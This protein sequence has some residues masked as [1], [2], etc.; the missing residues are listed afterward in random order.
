MSIEK[1][2]AVAAVGVIVVAAAVAV[3]VSLTAEEPTTEGDVRVAETDVALGEVTGETVE[4]DTVVRLAHRGGMTE[5]VSVVVRATRTD[6]GLL[7]AEETYDVGEV[8]GD[9]ETEVRVPVVVEREGD[10]GFDV[11]VYAGDERVTTGSKSVSG[12]GTVQPDYATSEL[13]FHSFPLQPAVEFSVSS[14]A[15]ETVELSTVSFLTNEG[16]DR[17]DATLVVKARQADSGIVA[18]EEE[19]DVSVAAGST[20][21]PSV[22]LTVPE[23]YDYYLDATLW[24][25]DNIVA[26]HRSAANLDPEERIEANETVRETGL[27]VE[28]F[29]DP[30]DEELAELRQQLEEDVDDEDDAPE[31][32]SGFG[33]VA[34]LVALV[35]FTLARRKK[36]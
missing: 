21:R 19:V 8:E 26:T 36:E 25:D 16:D 1:K 7:A 17:E 14:A 30:R 22:D 3:G 13:G 6:T 20:E 15:G 34:A 27:E 32:M 2:L 23:D 31:D 33:A 5:N 12:V 18:A 35:A 4:L 24:Q 29:A 10:Y 9:G 28:D 11:I